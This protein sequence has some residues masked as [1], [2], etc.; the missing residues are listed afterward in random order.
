MTNVPV[1]CWLSS[2]DVLELL[3]A[4]LRSL[5]I[6]SCISEL[7]RVGFF[8]HCFISLTDSS[9]FLFYFIYVVISPKISKYFSKIYEKTMNITNRDSKEEGEQ[10]VR[11]VVER[12]SLKY[13]TEKTN[14]LFFELTHSLLSSIF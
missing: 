12:H 8:S 11:I 3:T 10:L 1:S 9:A 14:N 7:W 5:H 2:G 13:L 6:A 4:S